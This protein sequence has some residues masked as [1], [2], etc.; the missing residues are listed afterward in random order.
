LFYKHLHDQSLEIFGPTLRTRWNSQSIHLK[1]EILD[2]LERMFGV[3]T[4]DKSEVSKVVGLYLKY[5]RDMYRVNL[6]KNPRYEHPP[7]IPEREWKA[8]IEDAKEK[9]LRKEGRNPP[10]P[11]R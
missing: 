4:F 9:R 2:Y 6:Q 10:G 3:D 7:I 1:K 11:G 8:F 5:I